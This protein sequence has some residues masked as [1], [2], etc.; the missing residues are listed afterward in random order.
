MTEANVANDPALLDLLLADAEAAGEPW[1][2]TPYWRGYAGRIARELRTRGLAAFRTNQRILKGFAFGG[3]ATPTLPQAGWKRALWRG[4][5]RL[6][7]V[8]R[9]VAEHRRLLRAQAR[10]AGSLRVRIA[11]LALDAIAERF[12][13]LRPPRNLA[14]G[15]AEDRFEWRGHEVTADWVTYLARAADFYAAVP[16]REVAGIVE[17]GGGLGHSLLAHMALNPRLGVAVHVDIVPV[18]YVSTQYLKAIPDLRVVDYRELRDAAEIAAVPRGGATVYQA[19]PWLLPKFAG[20]LD[21][22]FNAYSFQETEPEVAEAYAKHLMRLARRGG[23]LHSRPG[24][25][26]PGAGGQRRSVTLPFLE[27][28][29]ADAYPSVGRLDGIW[30]RYFAGTPEETR[31]FRRDPNPI[32]ADDPVR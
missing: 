1:V 15:G 30:P 16:A 32:A 3:A 21:Y 8:S 4:A 19:P 31:L 24:G 22:F 23:L 2:A 14:A 27:S 11:G 29:F 20:A 13:D 5:E 10:H 17:V 18:I 26:K 25:H 28:L 7:I 9:I 12:P 6:P